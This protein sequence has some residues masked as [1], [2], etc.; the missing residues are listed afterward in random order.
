[1]D[2]VWLRDAQD[3]GIATQRL[4][5]VGKTLAAE[6]RLVEGIRLHHGAH[7]AIDDQDAFSTR[8]VQSLPASF[9]CLFHGTIRDEGIACC[10]SQGHIVSW[11]ARE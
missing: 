8:L 7:G 10:P 5:P 1:M 4:F 9:T 2:D 3:V 11:L 6:C